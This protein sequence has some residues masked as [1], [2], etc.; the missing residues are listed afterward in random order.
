MKN[1][2]IRL[3][4]VILL[5]KNSLKRCSK[6]QKLLIKLKNLNYHHN[7]RNLITLGYKK[8]KNKNPIYNS[9]NNH[10]KPIFTHLR[11]ISSIHNRIFS[12]LV[13][14]IKTDIIHL[15]KIQEYQKTVIIAFKECKI[16]IFKVL[17]HYLLLLLF[18]QELQAR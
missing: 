4:L 15:F 5:V 7:L 10:Q 16:I 3:K 11:F 18:H 14:T 6:N 13:Q 8:L 1:Q 2:N 12:N 9:L 17:F